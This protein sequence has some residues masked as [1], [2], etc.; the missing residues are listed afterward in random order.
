[1]ILQAWVEGGILGTAF[2]FVLGFLLLRNLG[3]LALTRPIDA[4]SPILAYFCLY[5]LGHIA[6]S[7]FAAPLRVQLAL[8]AVSVVVV[9][10][11]QR[12]SRRRYAMRRLRPSPSASLQ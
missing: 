12:S 8:A 4:L 1:M 11:E 3:T 9:A 7:A 2:F 10:L 5:G 6:M